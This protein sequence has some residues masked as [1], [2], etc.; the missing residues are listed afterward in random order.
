MHGLTKPLNQH[1]LKDIL[2][3][4]DIDVGLFYGDFYSTQDNYP[5]GVVDRTQ[6][7]R[8]FI[9]RKSNKIV[10]YEISKALLDLRK[11]QWMSG[12]GD[13]KEEQTMTLGERMA[14]L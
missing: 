2:L 12:L 5:F 7:E 3:S 13:R 1:D 11:N 4:Q 6:R 14:K 8:I 9:H 10:R